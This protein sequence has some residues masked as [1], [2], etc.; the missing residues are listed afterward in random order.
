MN[1]MWVLSNSFLGLI[2]VIARSNRKRPYRSFVTGA[3]V[4]PLL[5]YFYIQLLF[6]IGIVETPYMFIALAAL[7]VIYIVSVL[8]IA[9]KCEDA[10]RIPRMFFVF[11]FGSPLLSY[12]ISFIYRLFPSL[13]AFVM[14]S[15]VGPQ[16]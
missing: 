8:I 7:V 11:A 15:H 14:S 4:Y 1:M 5:F 16:N 6:R 10:P 2:F 9:I 13:Q 3:F 12:T